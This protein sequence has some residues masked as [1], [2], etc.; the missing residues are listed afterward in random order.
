[1]TQTQ[2]AALSRGFHPVPDGHLAAV[3]T[4]LEMTAPPAGLAAPDWRDARLVPLG[5]PDP[6]AYRRLFRAVG[7]DWLWFSRLR[8]PEAALVAVLSDPAVDAFVL[9]RDGA[10]IG[11]LELDF[12]AGTEAELA[13]LGLVP[14]AAGQGLGRALMAEALRR[15]WARPIRRLTVHTCTLDSPAALPFYLQWGFTP[16]RREVEVTPDP[17]LTGD[18]PRGAAPQIPVLGS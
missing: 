10:D 17:R 14:E 13:F 16:F 3:V 18:L 11:L 12:R 6:A 1:M 7:A 8:M 4:H 2:P 9:R 5:P 15:A